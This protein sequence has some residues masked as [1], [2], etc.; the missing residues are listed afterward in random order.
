MIDSL[1]SSPLLPIFL[2]VAVDILGYTIILPLLPFYAE[3]MGATPAVVGMLVSVYAVCQLIAGPLLGRASDRVGRR[4]L[5]IVSQVGTLI[6]FLVLASATTLPIVFLSRIIDGVTAGNLTLAQAY[7][8]DVTPPENRAKSFGIIGIAFGLGFL[9]GPALSGFLSQFGYHYPIYAAAG[10]S[11][12]SITATTLILPRK[13][14]VVPGVTPVA[15]EAATGRMPIVQWA[16]YVQY[17]RRPEL[18]PLL[19]K[20]F[21]YVFSFSIFVGGFALFAERRYTWN[22]HPFG[23]KEVGYVFAFSGLIGG[24][25]QGGALGAMVRRF[26]ERP[27]MRAGLIAGSIGYL[28][29]AYAYTI[30]VLLISASISAFG[31]IVRPIVTSLITQVTDRRE[32]GTVLGLTQSLTS[33]AQIT[34]P[35]IAGM[36]IEHRL[37]ATWGVA[38]AAVAL[39]GWIVPTPPAPQVDGA[40]PVQS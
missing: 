15:P 24:T 12:I 27:L 33:V 13:P 2:I 26:G 21:S 8:S 18:W 36:L 4:P 38:A 6:G 35:L 25:L 3:R 39:A 40:P 11:A 37:L 1:R 5:L 16:R 9:V 31:G 30:P 23:P 14:P 17:F 29:L 34:G 19:A 10:L 20:F 22:G 32:Q 28:L 7:I